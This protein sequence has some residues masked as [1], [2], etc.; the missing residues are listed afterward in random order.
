VID[1]SNDAPRNSTS[2]GS[3]ASTTTVAT[4]V[5]LQIEL[6]FVFVLTRKRVGARCE[7]KRRGHQREQAATS[8]H[9]ANDIL[10]AECPACF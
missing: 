5:D 8:E 6:F 7:E 3:E 10:P 4:A 2:A 1:G 9:C